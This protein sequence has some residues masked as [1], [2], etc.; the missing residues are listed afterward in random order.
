VTG[1]RAL[2]REANAHAK[3]VDPRDEDAN[4]A[5]AVDDT[6]FVIGIDADRLRSASLTWDR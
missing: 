5:A 6:V 4:A 1:R 3:A 2:S